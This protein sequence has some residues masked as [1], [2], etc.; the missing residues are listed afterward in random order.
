MHR[1]LY[2]ILYIC[3]AKE[4][5]CFGTIELN[6]LKVAIKFATVDLLLRMRILS[7]LAVLSLTIRSV[8]YHP[9]DR[10]ID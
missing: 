2:K 9:I 5:L 6:R 7:L 3:N 8:Q 4:H 1:N 10:Q